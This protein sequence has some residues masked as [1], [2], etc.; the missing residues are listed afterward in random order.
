MAKTKNK[1]QVLVITH[2]HG[3]NFYAA[4]TKKGIQKEL[5]NYVKAWWKE[6]MIHE[7]PKGEIQAIEE[8]FESVSES[9]AYTLGETEIKN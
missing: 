5:F 6:E 9:E 3:T 4:K 7:M 2:K 1:I 8:Y